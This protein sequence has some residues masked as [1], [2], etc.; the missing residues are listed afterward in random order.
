MKSFVRLQNVNPGFNPHNILTAVVSLPQT[1]YPAPG[2][3]YLG[4][5]NAIKFFTDAQRRIS[6]LP[7]VE[8]SAIAALLPLSGSNSDASFEIED[9]PPHGGGPGPDEEIRVI[10]PDFF[11]VLQ[12]PLLQG[13][14]FN[15]ADTSTSPQVVIINEALARKYFPNGDALGKRITFDDTHKDPKWITIIGVVGSMRHRGLDVDPQA[16]YYLP[17]TQFP[18]RSMIVVARSKLDPR[19]LTSAIRNQIQSI[20]SELPIA[21]VRTLDEVV[22]DSI[23]PRRLS[24]V[25]LGVFA[26]IAVLLATVG[27]YGVMSFL[28]VQRTHEIGVRVALGAQRSD[29]VRLIVGHATKLVGIGTLIGLVLAFLSTR[30]LSALLYNV[31]AFDVATFVLVTVALAAVA[32]LASYI[33]AHRAARADPVVA[34]DHNA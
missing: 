2:P 17:H 7:G 34:L 15:E 32:L 6:Q 31:G 11:R 22:A 16:E 27:V 13:R 1:K 5:E 9:A 3:S 18:L 14:F 8:A 4:G 28:V 21:R 12:V 29:V 20:D 10:S 33:P 24:V 30:L 26:A 25:L 19:S 23:A